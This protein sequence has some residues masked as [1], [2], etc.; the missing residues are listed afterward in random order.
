MWNE[1]FNRRRRIREYDEIVQIIASGRS[2]ID[3]KDIN[4]ELMSLWD[5]GL[6]TDKNGKYKNGKAP[7][8][9]DDVSG[10]PEPKSR[11][12]LKIIG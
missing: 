10:S 7:K 1:P 5:A 4:S 12:T 6:I 3:Q 8:T 9:E 2:K 11:R